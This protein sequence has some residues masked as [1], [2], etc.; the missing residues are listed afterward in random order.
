VTSTR[1]IPPIFKEKKP[2]IK[3]KRKYP[4]VEASSTS[5]ERSWV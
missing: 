5:K 1:T 3:G 4:E 2:K